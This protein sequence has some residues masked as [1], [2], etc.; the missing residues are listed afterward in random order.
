[1]PA[2]PLPPDEHAR[3]AALRELNLLD[4]D[5]GPELH[6]I[7]TLAASVLDVPICLVSLV[8]EERLWFA[9]HHGT[10]G[11][12]WPRELSF[13]G[14]VVAGK[15][16][17]L[18]HDLR[19]DE[20]FCDSDLVMRRL[21]P[22]RF[23]A[24]VPLLFGDGHVVGT[25][26]VMDQ[27]P[28]PDFDERKLQQLLGF[29]EVVHDQIQLR[30]DRIQAEQAHTLF[31]S[32]PVG[33]VVWDAHMP[34]RPNYLSNNLQDIIGKRLADE[35]RDD[36]IFDDI[37][38]PDDRES[39]RSSLSSHHQ[40]LLPM[41]E[42]SYRLRPSSR[43]TR[44]VHQVNKADYN[45]TGEL[46]RIRSY[47]FDLT[48]HKQ[49]EASIEATKERLYLALESAR[50]GTWDVNNQTQ[51]LV[52]NARAAHMLGYR[53]D[54]V[55]H[56]NQSWL[57]LVHPHDRVNTNRALT[58]YSNPNMDVVAL[59]YRIR[60]KKGHY[61]W[62]QSY[63]RAVERDADGQPR[64]IV[65]TLI[66]ITESKC[67]EALRNRQRQ[68]LDLL[69]QAQTSFL[70]NRNVQDA[71]DALFEPL[72]RISESAFGFIGIVQ[73]ND[74]G[75]P[76]LNVPTISDLDWRQG[77]ARSGHYD[78]RAGGLQFHQL[79]NLFG[80]V[81]THN[82]I[83][84][85]NEPGTHHASQGTPP[86]HP[87]LRNFLGMPIRFDNKVLGM[88]ALGN[89]PDGFDEQMV[90]LLEPL[91]VTLGTLFHARDQ[92]TA[93]V[94]AEQELLRLATRDALTGLANRRYF[95]D[96]AETSLTQTRRYGSPMTVALLDL[97]HF[98]HIND[99]HGHAAGDTVLNTFADILRASL[100]DTDTPAR[101]GGEEFAVLLTNT[102]L[103]EA[104]IAL[105]RIRHTLD[106][107][108]IQVGERT[109]YATVSIGAVQWNANH[110]D[111]DGML[112]HADAALYAA[113]RHGRNRVQLYH[114]DLTQTESATAT[115]LKAA[116]DSA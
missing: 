62:V 45:E 115:P 85:T 15:R 69:N 53:E 93:R 103:S 113:K 106:E 87:V 109:I 56:N 86:G 32:G 73:Y 92:E 2:A 46:Q 80:H 36:L 66:D 31:S 29:S 97:D 105:E 107:T 50:I 96:V 17:I 48:R 5:G 10:D 18:A 81:I 38:H 82:Q 35:L 83:V 42:I 71:C 30:Q 94:A 67:Q 1:M 37:V 51:E 59:E 27:R 4:Q 68:L 108:P 78:R 28:R 19:L 63:G 7:T 25:L 47:L 8:D 61:V 24:G 12:Q 89:R 6:R 64:R 114:P 72:L 16:V 26:C 79:D 41:L 116:N 22:L 40:G 52:V 90:Q 74:K 91:V 14:H 112:A 58:H 11:N 102:P 33:T 34:P 20:R 9:A 99:T 55:E 44:W 57:D 98:K 49:L 70:L 76:Y 111:V 104:L 54:E 21:P 13:C 88:I 100:R 39:V 77:K 23:Y 65:G 43:G 95:F 110:L 101:V 75:Q 84:L 3:L 60:H